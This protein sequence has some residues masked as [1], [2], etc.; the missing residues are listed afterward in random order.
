MN[1]KKLFKNALIFV[2]LGI[3]RNLLAVVWIAVMLFI[4]V[5]IMS[6]WFPLGLILPI[7]YLPTFPLFT[8]TYAAY[9][10]IKRYMI[11]PIPQDE[12]EE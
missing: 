2:V 4:N 8:T 9:P 7:L 6:V 11:D 1:I 3:K 12:S 10:I 5:M